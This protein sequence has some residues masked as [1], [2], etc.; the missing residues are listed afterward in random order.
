MRTF[1]YIAKY[2]PY[3]GSPAELEKLKPIKNYNRVMF[4]VYI[5]SLDILGLILQH[6]ARSKLMDI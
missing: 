3:V 5:L 1:K 4:K 2:L 6:D